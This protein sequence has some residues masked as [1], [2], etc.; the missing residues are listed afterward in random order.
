M[1]FR[2]IKSGLQKKFPRVSKN[3]CGY[4]LDAIKKISD[5][6]KII[7][8]SEGTLGVITTVKLKTLPIPAKRIL[9][10]LAYKT[11]KQAALDSAKIVNLKPSALE[12]I[13]KNIA[14]HIKDGLKSSCL[15]FVEFDDELDKC[16]ENLREIISG[17][18]VVKI[19]TGDSEIRKWWNFRN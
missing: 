5:L 13:D 1:L 4:R 14:K 19:L 15:L 17:T 3:S 16:K 8:A 12:I 9:V 6:H 10:I 11:I 18:Q 2:S 7:A